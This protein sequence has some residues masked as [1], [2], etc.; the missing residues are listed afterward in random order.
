MS[1]KKLKQQIRELSAGIRRLSEENKRLLDTHAIVRGIEELMPAASRA[2]R[3]F[4]KAYY[5]EN[6]RNPPDED[7]PIDEDLDGDAFPSV[8]VTR[9]LAA[10]SHIQWTATVGCFVLTGEEDE[11][12]EPDEEHVPFAFGLPSSNPIEAISSLHASLQDTPTAYGTYVPREMRDFE[13]DLIDDPDEPPHDP[14]TCP[15]CKHS[16]N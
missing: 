7:V 5:G 13:D 10:A 1:E 15:N 14:A 6:L 8:S 11:D 2:Y 12:G 4:E 9:N 3:L 16:I